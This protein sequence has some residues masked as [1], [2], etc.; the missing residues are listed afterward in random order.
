M[1]DADI[2]IVWYGNWTTTSTVNTP[3]TIS[4]LMK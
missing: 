4:T 3:Q 1:G 2:V